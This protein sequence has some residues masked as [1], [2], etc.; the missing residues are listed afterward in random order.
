[1]VFEQLG[2]LGVEGIV[3]SYELLGAESEPAISLLFVPI[4]DTCHLEGGCMVG[5]VNLHPI[6]DACAVER[7][8][9]V[10]KHEVFLTR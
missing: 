5:A 4:V 2:A 3:V 6:V 1:M 10:G 9:T 7:E 8:K